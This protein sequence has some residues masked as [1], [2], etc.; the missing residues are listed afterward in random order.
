MSN[1]TLIRLTRSAQR[2]R[3][4][5]SRARYR[6]FVDPL[7]HLLLLGRVP[8]R[9]TP[10]ARPVDQAVD[11]VGVVAMRPVSQ[12]L[13]V[14]PASLGRQGSFMSV[15]NHRNRKDPTRLLRRR[16]LRRRRP[17]LRG[18]QIPARDLNR[19]HRATP[20]HEASSTHVPRS[21]GFLPGVMASG[22]WYKAAS[23]DVAFQVLCGGPLRMDSS[24]CWSG[25]CCRALP[26]H[27]RHPRSPRGPRRSTA[28]PVGSG[29]RGR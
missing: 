16:C 13:A 21:L 6:T 10:R 1:T 22:G 26:A 17:Q 20:N 25:S 9:S 23:E 5:P 7:R 18:A 2:Q 27:R 12:G 14:H 11:A 19:R 24:G 3:T 8:P 15:Q 29:R 4:T 28:G